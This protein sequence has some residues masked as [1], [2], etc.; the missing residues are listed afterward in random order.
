M[1]IHIPTHM[2]ACLYFGLKK[3][4]EMMQKTTVILTGMNV[5][6]LCYQFSDHDAKYY[7][8]DAVSF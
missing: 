1:Y 5:F 3:Y 6:L 2:F 4:P 8:I 7:H